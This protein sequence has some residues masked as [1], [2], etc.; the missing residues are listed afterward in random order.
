MKSGQ[1]LLSQA[2]IDSSNTLSQAVEYSSA[3]QLLKNL[4]SCLHQKIGQ[5]I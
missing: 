5:Y 3:L 2:M 4:L 1:N